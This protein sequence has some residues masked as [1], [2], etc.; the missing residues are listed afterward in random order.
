MTRL[1]RLIVAIMLTCALFVGASVVFAE[2]ASATVDPFLYP[3]YPGSAS[4]SSIFDHSSPTY[5]NDDKRIVT[6]NGHKA[7]K[8][9]P[10]PPPA[11]AR[12]PG[13]VCDA[14]YNI[15]WSYSLGDW[16]S[17]NGHDGIDYGISYR[18]IYAAADADQVVYAGWWNPQ[19]H[20]S[21][22][23][24]YVRLHHPNGY[25]S[26]YG[27]MSSV[28]V[29]TC[30]TP[31][32]VYLS[33]GEMLGI[34]GT[35]GNSTG[36][37]LHFQVRNENAKVIDPYGWTG[38]GA[39]PWSY[40]QP[41]SLW[42]TYPALIYYGAEILPS[43]GPLAYP[44]PVTGGFII[45][46]G[47]EGFTESPVNCWTVTSTSSAT[48]GAMRY[49]KPRLSTPNCT[50]TWGFPSNAAL[51]VYEVYI[52][53]PAVRATSQGAVY[54]LHHA[55]EDDQVVINQ[56]VFPNNFYVTDGWVYVGKYHFNGDGTE[57]VQLTNRTQDQPGDVGG[58]DLGADSIRFVR[59]G[60]ATPTPPQ[61]VTVTPSLTRT[62]TR[63]PTHTF[64]P[65]IT[66]T[67]TASRTPTNTRTFTPTRTST[68][69]R[70]PSNTPTASYTPT[71]SKTPT[72]SRTPT[73]TR[74]PT[75]T[76][77]YTPTRTA[78]FTR[79]ATSTRT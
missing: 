47:S 36:P 30:T 22:V 53:I 32:C 21:N 15:Y 6:F 4:Q 64:T 71:A 65:T 8:E 51:G 7:F 56:N 78:T 41:Q 57:Y 31:G 44:A 2:P 70:T 52:R 58:L 16:V 29:Q 72:A 49:V 62:P 73:S 76:R 59:L 67:P 42:V 46:D 75:N 19:D 66:R 34:S 60:D 63:T 27:H 50:A 28:A 37:H 25:T 35:T 9:C 48:N 26:L 43:G 12:P 61:I 1:T 40:N 79:T 11:G 14:G 39:D 54:T 17:Y 55:G 45:D 3:P 38:A 69:T 20:S 18:P 23:G 74:T 10:V 24:I 77:T 68:F 5:N 33:H 13:G